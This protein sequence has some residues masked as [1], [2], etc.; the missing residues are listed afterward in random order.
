MDTSEGPAG[1]LELFV[2]VQAGIRLAVDASSVLRILRPRPLS[3]LMGGP[4]HLRQFFYEAGDVVPILDIPLL[5]GRGARLQ[6]P[7]RILLLGGRGHRI[8]FCV[9]GVFGPLRLSLSALRAPEFPL[10]PRLA[11]FV[12]GLD[13]NMTVVLDVF[14]LL[15]SL[16][17]RR[18][19]LEVT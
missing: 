6:G 10:D 12:R 19:L 11:D 18:R 15:E 13:E 17:V 3:P 16:D 4:P 14:A 5:L 1:E 7:A 2:F 8:G 9:E